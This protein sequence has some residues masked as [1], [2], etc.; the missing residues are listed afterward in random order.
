MTAT[1]ASGVGLMPVLTFASPVSLPAVLFEFVC[2]HAVDER[3]NRPMNTIQSFD[4]FTIRVL[5][6]FAIPLRL[7]SSRDSHCRVQSSSTSTREPFSR[8]GAKMTQN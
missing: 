8:Q 4:L 5:L 2:L 3:S 7:W 1:C 6:D